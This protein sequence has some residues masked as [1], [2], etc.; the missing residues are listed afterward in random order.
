MR[1]A[2]KFY[3]G[4]QSIAQQSRNDYLQSLTDA[5]EKAQNLCETTG[6]P[7]IVVQ[8]VRIVRPQKMPV[9]VEVVI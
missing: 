3:V 4:S 7:Q 5:I 2:K 6:E 9:K 8:I 1:M